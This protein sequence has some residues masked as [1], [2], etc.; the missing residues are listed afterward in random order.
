MSETVQGKPIIVI[1]I[2]KKLMN[3][4]DII[5]DYGEYFYKNDSLDVKTSFH[6]RLSNIEMIRVGL[7]DNGYETFQDFKEDYERKEALLLEDNVIELGDKI[8]EHEFE[9]V[10]K[11]R[12]LDNVYNY[13]QR[14]SFFSLGVEH[15]KNYILCEHRD[16]N[17]Y[18]HLDCG[19]CA[20]EI[21]STHYTCSKCGNL[22]TKERVENIIELFITDDTLWG[23][24][25]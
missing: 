3:C 9:Y 17:Y 20:K 11:D 25:Y 14:S 4:D 5:K 23:D 15:K 12:I 21:A 22:F 1:E 10:G 2:D 24:L 13:Y 16:V 6:M 7:L 19:G 18:E 8:I